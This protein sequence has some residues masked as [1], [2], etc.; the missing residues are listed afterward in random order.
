[1]MEREF[2]EWIRLAEDKDDIANVQKGLG[3]KRKSTE[4]K[5]SMKVVE[6]KIQELEEKKKK[7]L[8]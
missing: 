7:L 8:H 4:A 2:V 3:L 6:R 5:G 1:M